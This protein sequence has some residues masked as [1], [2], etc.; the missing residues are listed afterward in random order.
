[1]YEFVTQKNYK[2]FSEHKKKYIDKP[3][4]KEI[5]EIETSTG[6]FQAELNHHTIDYGKFITKNSKDLVA[7]Y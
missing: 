7:S 3:P 5:G 6:T 2:K 1:M 4:L